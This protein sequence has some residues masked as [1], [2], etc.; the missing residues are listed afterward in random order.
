MKERNCLQPPRLGLNMPGNNINTYHNWWQ[1]QSRQKN[2]T[3]DVPLK[4]NFVHP[5]TPQ[6]DCGIYIYIII[7]IYIYL[8]LYLLYIKKKTDGFLLHDH[9]LC[10]GKLCRKGVLIH[11]PVQH[12]SG[13]Q[14]NHD[15]TSL[16]WWEFLNKGHHSKMVAIIRR[17]SL[18]FSQMVHQVV[19]WKSRG[20]FFLRPLNY[21]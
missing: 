18:W 19:P 11:S 10:V 1:Q 2:K 8:Y 16:E 12:H 21:G 20:C 5:F 14:Q 7:Y 13:P 9:F 3:V 6:F 17:E 15:V 4:I